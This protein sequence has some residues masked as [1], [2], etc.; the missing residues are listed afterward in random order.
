MSFNKGTHHDAFYVTRLLVAHILA[1]TT[2][3]K[4]LW[5]LPIL[6]TYDSWHSYP[7]KQPRTLLR[8]QH[9]TESQAR[10]THHVQGHTLTVTRVAFSPCG[11]FL[12][13]CSRDRSF[14]IFASG[15]PSAHVGTQPVV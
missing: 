13:S 2:M 11:A 3:P 5:K 15:A 10:G 8:S 14:C 12:A 9:L 4:I 6:C 7:T 1:C